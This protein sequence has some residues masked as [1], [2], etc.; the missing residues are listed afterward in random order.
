MLTILALGIICH[1]RAT[2]KMLNISATGDT[3]R[4]GGTGM[5]LAKK[6]VALIALLV[7]VIAAGGCARPKAVSEP[8]PEPLKPMAVGKR[9]LL[10]APQSDFS[11]EEFETLESEFT[12]QGAKLFLAAPRG[13]TASSRNEKILAAD[14]A[15]ELAHAEQYDAVVFLGGAGAAT[16]FKNDAAIRLAKEAA[17]Q[18]KPLGASGAATLI[19][20]LA[21]VLDNKQATTSPRLAKSFKDISKCIYVDKPV[22]VDEKIVTTDGAKSSEEYAKMLVQQLQ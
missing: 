17:E 16:L 8:L 19:L 9:I 14:V 3:F 11:D 1:E 6:F 7:L 13:T 5:L 10:V 2:V 12:T 18:H 15:L 22:V 21:G 20:G 4:I